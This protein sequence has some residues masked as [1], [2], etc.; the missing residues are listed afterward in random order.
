MR[1]SRVVTRAAF[2]SWDRSAF[3]SLQDR[4][5]GR[6]SLDY[7]YWRIFRWSAKQMR[8]FTPWKRKQ[9]R[10]FCEREVRRMGA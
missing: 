5:A 8:M 3:R 9:L 2:D 1:R 4:S 7:S 10:N 6:D